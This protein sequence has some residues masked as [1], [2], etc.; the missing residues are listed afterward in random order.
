MTKNPTLAEMVRGGVTL[1]DGLGGF[2]AIESQ[3]VCL[4][5]V[6]PEEDAAA[7]HAILARERRGLYHGKTEDEIKEIFE[8]VRGRFY[9]NAYV[10]Y[11]AI[12]L[13]P[14][15]QMI[16]NVRFW[17]WAGHPECPL[18][19]GTIQYDLSGPSASA[20]IAAEALRA[21][22]E[23]G[24]SRLGLARVQCTV[25]PDDAVK[26]EAL[27]AAGFRKEGTLRSWWFDECSQEWQDEAMFS[28]VAADISK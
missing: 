19:F 26:S 5:E 7:W 20:A 18:Q 24:L 22:A 6:R 9:S 13:K 23:F 21:V 4:R 28:F 27:L 8:G 12:A 2:P 25:H 17:E 15:D 1:N 10:I 3:S 16:G 14:D 11:W